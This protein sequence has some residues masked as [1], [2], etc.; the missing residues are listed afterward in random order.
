MQDLQD[1]E[2]NILKYEV[3]GKLAL[4]SQKLRLILD[5]NL[6]KIS[7]TITYL[8]VSGKDLYFL[9]KDRQKQL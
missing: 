7:L 5:L 4:I 9:L 2:K 1:P 3:I 8:N 6:Q